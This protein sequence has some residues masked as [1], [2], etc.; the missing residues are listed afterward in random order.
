MML[1]EQ[2]GYVGVTDERCEIMG[3]GAMCE[4]HPSENFLVPSNAPPKVEPVAAPG[5]IPKFK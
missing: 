4:V 3:T 5:N 2:E 1:K